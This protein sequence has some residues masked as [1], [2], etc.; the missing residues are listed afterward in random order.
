MIFRSATAFLPEGPTIQDPLV[1]KVKGKGK[2]KIP[3]DDALGAQP[4]LDCLSQWAKEKGEEEALTVAVVGVANVRL[5]TIFLSSYILIYLYIYHQVGKSSLINSLLKRAALPIYTLASSSRG[6]S[7]TE[8]AQKVT[9]EIDSQKIVLIDTP[10]FSFVSDDD[11]DADQS[12]STEEFRARDILLRNKGRI[13][14]LKDPHPPGTYYSSFFYSLT[15]LT[16]VMVPMKIVAHIVS[17]ANAEDLMLLY[18]LPA[19]T[20][21]DVS[22]FLSGVARSNQLVKKVRFFFL[23]GVNVKS[24]DVLYFYFFQ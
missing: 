19:F 2:A 10:A 3:I 21:G 23:I 14:R 18:S 17:R 6:P 4:L 16:I 1:K 13:D 7:T 24:A 5:F 22:A 8:I 12:T 20:N 15:I 11:E 9:L